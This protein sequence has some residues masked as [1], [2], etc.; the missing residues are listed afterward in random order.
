MLRLL[1]RTPSSWVTGNLFHFVKWKLDFWNVFDWN[2][3]TSTRLINA[4]LPT[5]IRFTTLYKNIY[6]TRRV[7]GYTRFV[8]NYVT[9]RSNH[10]KYIYSRWGSIAESIWPWTSVRYFHYRYCPLFPITVVQVENN[11]TSK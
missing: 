5:K 1:V 11:W 3:K 9:G 6:I 7:K 4:Q 8:E 2:L 10:I